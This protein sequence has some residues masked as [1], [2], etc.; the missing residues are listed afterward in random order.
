MQRQCLPSAGC[1]LLILM[2]VGLGACSKPA[3]R[4]DSANDDYWT[5]AMHPSVRSENFGQCPICGMDLIPVTS[6]TLESSGSS[7]TSRSSGDH[8]ATG[9]QEDS[10][11]TSAKDDNI[12]NF[13]PREVFVPMQRQQQFGVTCTEARRR[14]MRLRFRSVG[15][16]EVD[17]SQIFECVAHVD[18]YIDQLQVASS[19]ERV[20]VGQ[21]LMTIN[22]PD[23]RSAEQELISLLRV[24]A[25]GNAPQ[26]ALIQLI[27][28]ARRRLQRMNVAPDQI[29]E[30]ERTQ[31][32]TDLLLVRSPCDGIVSQASMRVGLSVKHGDKLM[33]LLNLSRLWLWASFYENEVDLLKEGELMTAVFPAL[34]NRSFEGKISVITPTIDPVK[35]TTLARID[36]EN[37]EGQLRPGMNAN[38]IADID[39]GEVLSIPFDSV[40]PVGSQMLVFADVGFG[41][42]EPRL[43]HVGRQF[44][45][46]ADDNEERYYQIIGGLQEGE[47]IVL[48][49]NFLIEA[50]AQ[51]QGVLKNFGAEKVPGSIGSGSSGPIEEK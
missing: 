4:I 32:P 35:R 45:D 31:R 42:L 38:V 23:L 19:G 9:H 33:L 49:G 50:E 6:Q 39:G 24:Q 29:S 30:L 12:D 2:L 27:D 40:L 36:I 8:L 34:A 26:A 46:P 14:H 51:I 10:S 44:V 1:S 11:K 21:P 13:K 47:R 18:G 41:K 22:T 48:T 5:C 16:L 37:P 3:S 25:S 43:I 20:I 28:S 17:Q 15:T 7:L